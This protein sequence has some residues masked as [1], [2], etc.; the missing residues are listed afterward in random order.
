MHN[1][2]NDLADY[3][4]G[5]IS[6][7]TE[8]INRH[9]HQLEQTLTLDAGLPLRPWFKH[10]IF[11]PGLHSGY[12]AAVFPGIQDALEMN[13]EMQVRIQTDRL[14][15]AFQRITEQI[16]QIRSTVSQHQLIAN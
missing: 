9:L 2:H 3:L 1:L 7:E 4:K 14:A 16:E 6:I 12:A 13:D 11:A 8:A 5:G 15:E 10:L